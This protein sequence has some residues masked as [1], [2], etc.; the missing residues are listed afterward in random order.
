M[1]FVIIVMSWVS[2]KIYG[3]ITSW[4]RSRTGFSQKTPS[5]LCFDNADTFCFVITGYGFAAS[6]SKDAG[7]LQGHV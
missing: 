2:V 1:P 4:L 5:N 3:R 6:F 7:L